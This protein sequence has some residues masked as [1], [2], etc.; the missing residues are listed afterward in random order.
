MEKKNKIRFKDLSGWLKFAFIWTLISV[1]CSIFVFVTYPLIDSTPTDRE[2]DMEN[3]QE[4]IWSIC[5]EDDTYFYDEYNN[6]C[7]CYINHEL[8]IDQLMPN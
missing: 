2:I 6:Q 4:C 7:S 1:V 5:E 3:E 8:T